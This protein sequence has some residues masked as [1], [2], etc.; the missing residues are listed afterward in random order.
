MYEVLS[1]T[2]KGRLLDIYFFKTEMEVIL[3]VGRQFQGNIVTK[4][5]CLLTL[6][7]ALARKSGK[8]NGIIL[9]NI[10]HLKN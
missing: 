9:S 6:K 7:L 1:S 5:Y 3:A 10:Q 4:T 8:S 2:N